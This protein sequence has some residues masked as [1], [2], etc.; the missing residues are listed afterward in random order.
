MSAGGD[1]PARSDRLACTYVLPLRRWR[2]EPLGELADH[3]AVLSAVCDEVV[4]VDGSDAAVFEG[5]AAQLPPAVRHVP[6]DEDQ[7]TPNGKVGGVVTGVRSARNERV[8]IADDDVR[9]DE[10]SLRRLVAELEHAHL[11]RPQNFFSP[12]LPWHARWDTARTLLNRAVAADHPGTFGVRRSALLA[13]GGYDGSVLFENLE[14]VRTIR[15]GGGT[16]RHLPDL[17][18]A[19]LAPSTRQFWA[20]RVRQAY[21]S[22]AT[23]GRLLF[24]LS[25]LP[26]AV[27]AVVR[28]CPG[29]LVAASATAVAV[30]ERGRR[31]AGGAPVFPVSASLAAP[32]WLGERAVC[33]WLALATRIGRGGVRYAGTTLVAAAHSDRQLRRRLASRP[34]LPTLASSAE[35]QAP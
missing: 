17:Y 27:T 32:L 13:T 29:A 5:H 6:P 3:L 9:Y 28:G 23:P 16:V 30:A 11:V 20:Q 10:A 34:P 2:A 8:V 18:V 19:R 14:L 35:R 12:P 24:E 33:A 15:A 4:V 7:R 21:D 25:L 26:A 31:L 1:P 22:F